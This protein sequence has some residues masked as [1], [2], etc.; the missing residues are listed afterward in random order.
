MDPNYYNQ[1]PVTST[2][3]SDAAAG[4]ALA[5][6]GGILLF[7]LFF[8]II[9]YVY[10]AI[11]V[12]KM[13]KKTGTEN[14]W[15]AWIPILNLILLIQIARKPIWWIIFFFIPILNIIF[16]ILVWMAVAKALGKPEWLGILMI[17]P[18]ANFIILGYLAF[19]HSDIAPVAA[20]QNPIPPAPPINPIQ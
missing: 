5:V 9:I 10:T 20:P 17:V 18:V 4:T 7:I 2:H 13:A 3:I 16:A 8:V 11:C 14:A 12:M 19:S 6:F 15:M 1:Y